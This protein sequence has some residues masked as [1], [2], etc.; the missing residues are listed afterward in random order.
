ME[1]AHSHVD[2]LAK[3]SRKYTEKKDGF[4]SLKDTVLFLITAIFEILLAKTQWKVKK[5]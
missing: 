4:H 5:F 1:D 3:T 2:T